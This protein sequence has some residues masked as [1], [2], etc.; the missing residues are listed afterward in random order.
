MIDLGLVAILPWTD[1]FPLFDTIPTNFSGCGG[2]K[3]VN[4][5]A[6]ILLNGVT[7]G[8][9]NLPT[10]KTPFN[11]SVIKGNEL[12]SIENFNGEISENDKYFIN[13]VYE[14]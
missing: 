3:V 13:T 7:N 10:P 5:K 14:I 9:V 1:L 11:L 6:Y 4:S 2:Y 8:V 12:I